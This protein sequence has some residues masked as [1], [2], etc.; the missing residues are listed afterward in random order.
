MEQLTELVSFGTELHSQIVLCPGIN[1]AA[2]LEKSFRD[3][4]ALWPSV[5]SMAIVPVGLT[6]FRDE[7]HTL[8]GFSAAGAAAVID[9]VALWQEICREQAGDSFVYLADEFYLAAG[10]PIPA[11]EIYGEFPQLENGVGIVRCFLDEWEQ[12]TVTGSYEKPL[13]ISVVCGVSAAKILGPLLAAVKIPNLTVNLLPVENQFFG[14]AITVTG[15]LTG[16]DI[17]AA[18]Q[19]AGGHIDGVIVPGIAL[20]KG[21]NVFL[22]DMALEALESQL[23]I[24]VRTARFAADLRQLLADWR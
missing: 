1:D 24:P 20:R 11:Y 13:C 5:L 9:Q 18:L 14:P 7:C 4:F 2:V 6:R 3:L 16:Q 21:E 12:T 17:L 8:D 15:L 10:R 22:D 23:G 19:T